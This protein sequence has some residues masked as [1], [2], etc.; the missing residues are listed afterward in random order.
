MKTF[1]IY[2]IIL[3]GF[4]CQSSF[5]Q[6]PHILELNHYPNYLTF[7][8]SVT[9]EYSYS[10]TQQPCVRDSVII[11]PKNDTCIQIDVHYFVGDAQSPCLGNDVI[12]LDRMAANTYS[13]IFNLYSIDHSSE[14]LYSTSDTIIIDIHGISNFCE[15]LQI[16]PA[17]PIENK[18]TKIIIHKNSGGNTDFTINNDSI[19]L[20][21]YI[22]SVVDNLGYWMYVY[23]TVDVGVLNKGD[24]VL[25]YNYIDV[26]STPDMI[27][28]SKT[29]NFKVNEYSGIIQQPIESDWRIFPNPAN[30]FIIIENI[31]YNAYSNEKIYMSIFD[32]NGKELH[33]KLLN[34][35]KSIMDISYFE[36]G[37]YIIRII[38]NI[39][40]ISR[41][42]QKE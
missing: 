32:L 35:D 10:F 39:K 24:W 17:I 7:H 33:S 3:I 42:I 21:T 30:D 12:K 36:N 40:T 14:N 27:I 16:E 26:A 15:F 19:I 5:G 37:T 34:S 29:I 11:S 22:A 1:L 6:L 13:I 4:V 18:S 8:D 20:N 2:L 28:C 31:K 25:E 9:I 23:D 38:D 41:L